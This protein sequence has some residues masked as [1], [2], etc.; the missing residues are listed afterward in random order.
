MK[1]GASDLVQDT[2]LDGHRHF[3]RF[4]G[5]TE[6][7]LLAWLRGILL[8]NL[9]NFDR[10]YRETAKRRIACERPFE[11]ARRSGRGQPRAD[12][13]PSPSWNAVAR[14]ETDSLERAI[15]RL[16]VDYA[17][18]IILI[19][20]E[21]LSFLAAAAA[22]NRSVDATRRLWRGPSNSSPTN[23]TRPMAANEARPQDDAFLSSLAEYHESLSHN[24]VD[25][26][27]AD[28]TTG[29]DPGLSARLKRAQDCVRRLHSW[30]E[31]ETGSRLRQPLSGDS[32]SFPWVSPCLR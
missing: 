8:N 14:E 9:S 28:L 10:H 15:V 22:M 6:E 31:D 19:H 26:A 18:I 25:G 16:P 1:G 3:H 24:S 7:E 2:F 30:G 12:A 4:K 21:N 23:W 29:A 11:A 32:D 20:R 5:E 27:P 13:T 17:R